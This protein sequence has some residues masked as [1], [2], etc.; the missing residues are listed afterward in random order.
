MPDLVACRVLVGEP[1]SIDTKRKISMF[2][3]VAVDQVVGIHDVSSVY[4]VPLLLKN[5]DIIKFL[6]KRLGLD[7]V[8]I[9]KELHEKGEGLMKRWKDM[10]DVIGYAPCSLLSGLTSPRKN[11]HLDEVSIVLVGKYTD[12]PDSYMSVV[13]SLEHS[14]SRC[15]RK[16][17]L[18]VQW[19]IH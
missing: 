2:C 11:K 15:R 1:L 12:M 10:T 14:A 6:Q 19:C 16:L 8:S 9:S 5:Q 17:R 3:H 13:K 18:E 7:S 4:H